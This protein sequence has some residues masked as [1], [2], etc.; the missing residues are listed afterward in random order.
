MTKAR[1][2]IGAAA[3]ATGVNIET[4]RYYE[5]I[6]LLPKPPR[7]AGGQR[8]FDDGD[9]RKLA[10]IRRCRELGF[11]LAEIRILLGLAGAESRTC[12]EVKSLTETQLRNIR[13]KIADLKRMESALG[14]LAESCE[15]GSSPD[16]PILAELFSS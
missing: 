5:R 16:C 10:F 14:A 2:T 1:A 12:A 13:G 11:P 9:R 4:I 8:L 15:G 7:G 6:G 3:K